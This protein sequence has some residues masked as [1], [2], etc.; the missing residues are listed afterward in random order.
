MNKE[1]IC[2]IFTSFN[3]LNIF[4]GQKMQNTFS[5]HEFQF[6]NLVKI[7]LCLNRLKFSYFAMKVKLVWYKQQWEHQLLQ[8]S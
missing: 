2:K 3:I 7:F 4:K 5:L 8:L 6:S 1:I